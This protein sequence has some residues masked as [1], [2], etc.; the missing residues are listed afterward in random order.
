[1]VVYFFFFNV[2]AT[3]EIYTYL[4]TL[5]LHDALPI[6]R[7]L[8]EA[9]A[10]AVILGWGSAE[11]GDGSITG[12]DGGALAF[13]RENV[14]GLLLDLPDLFSDIQFQAGQIGRAHV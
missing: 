2:S 8:S 7:L 14:I 11:H 4:H 6:S 13:T 10:E 3:T 5:S 1:M 12:K 9:Y